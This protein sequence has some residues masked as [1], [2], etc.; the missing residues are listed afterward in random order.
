[1]EYISVRKIGK[2]NNPI[3]LNSNFG[4]SKDEHIGLFVK[5]PE[6]GEIFIAQGVSYHEEG[7]RTTPVTKVINNNTFQTQNSI[8][9]WNFIKNTI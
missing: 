6:E 9:Q 8:Y 4:E 1:M 5:L 2:V 3:N 7:I